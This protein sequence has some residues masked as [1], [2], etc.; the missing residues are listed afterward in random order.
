M[1]RTFLVQSAQWGQ[2]QVPRSC[3]FGSKIRHIFRE[4][5]DDG[6]FSPNLATTRKSMSPRNVSEAI[7]RKFCWSLVG[8]SR[9]C[10]VE[11]AGWIEMPLHTYRG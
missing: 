9:E 10:I 11:M 2:L 7:F 5:S 8:W 4:L 6:G 1:F 3:V